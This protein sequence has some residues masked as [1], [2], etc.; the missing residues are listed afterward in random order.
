MS[1]FTVEGRRWFDGQNTYHSVHV[2][3]FG[4]DDSPPQQLTVPFAYG[5]GTQYELTAL[6]HLRDLGVL[7]PAGPKHLRP[8]IEATG[9]S[10]SSSVTDVERRRNLHSLGQ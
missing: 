4:D 10:L 3:M 7:P 1:H 8:A 9:S 6:R 5:G 2:Q